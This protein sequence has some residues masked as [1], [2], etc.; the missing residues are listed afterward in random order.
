MKRQ[1]FL[2]AAILAVLLALRPVSAFSQAFP[3][4]AGQGLDE[5]VQ[6]RQTLWDENTKWLPRWTQDRNQLVKCLWRMETADKVSVDSDMPENLLAV[7]LDVWHRPVSFIVLSQNVLLETPIY[8]KHIDE[9]TAVALYR[10]PNP[11]Y[12]KYAFAY[13]PEKILMSVGGNR[14][15]FIHL[16]VNIPTGRI[17]REVGTD[18]YNIWDSY[19]IGQIISVVDYLYDNN[20]NHPREALVSVFRPI[21]QTRN[22]A[23]IQ[24]LWL[25]Q[26]RYTF[27]IVGKQWLIQQIDTTVSDYESPADWPY[28][29]DFAWQHMANAPK[30]EELRLRYDELAAEILDEASVKRFHEIFGEGIKFVPMPFIIPKNGDVRTITFKYLD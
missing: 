3:E 17:L 28:E 26:K 21:M 7:H 22:D 23:E 2:M 27:D 1:L 25:S 4:Y 12:D 30:A 18:Q 11:E 29:L 13:S 6:F 10:N 14:A 8:F 5:W 24:V 15:N 16:F 19:G 20:A 9:A